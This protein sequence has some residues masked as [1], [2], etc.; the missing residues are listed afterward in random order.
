VRYFVLILAVLGFPAEAV[1]RLDTGKGEV[2]LY[3]KSYALVVG[4]SAYKHWPRLPGVKKDVALVK[5][6]L[7]K[8][9]FEVTTVMDPTRSGFDRA[10]RAF[11]AKQGQDATARL[12]F[13]YAG[14]GYT[15]KGA[16][17]QEMGYMVPVDTPLPSGGRG[18]IQSTAVSMLEIEIY[19]KQMD[20]KHALFLF[21]SCFSGSIFSLSRAVPAAIS[22]KTTKAVR[23][24]ITAG[25]ADQEVPDDSVF[26]RQF[27]AALDGDAD[28]NRDGYLTASELS[29]FLEESVIN[30]TRGAQT[31]QYGKIRDPYLDKGDFVFFLPR[32]VASPAV[33]RAAPRAPAKVDP[34][35]VE[36]SYWESIRASKDPALYQAYLDRYPKGQ[37]AELARIF[38]QSEKKAE[39]ARKAEK[40]RTEQARREGPKPGTV[41]DDCGDCPPMVVIPAG[42]FTMGSPA[43]ETGRWDNEGPQRKV[44]IARPFALGRNEVTFAE[45]ER[46]VEESGYKTEAE[47]NVGKKGCFGFNRV[48]P[49]ATKSEWQPGRTWRDPGIDQN[50]DRDPVV[51]VSWNDAK[52]YTSWLS[53]KTGKTYRL[54]TE[55]E[56]EYAARAGTKTSRYWGDNPSQACVYSNVGD[57]STYRTA[58]RR[59]FSRPAE[60]RHECNDGRYYTAPVG[61]YK[62][63]AFGLYDILGNVWEWTED[64]GSPSYKGAPTDGSALLTGDCSRRVIRG[65]GWGSEPRTVRSA[66]RARDPYDNRTTSIGFRLARTLE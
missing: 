1:L 41:F 18:A 57:Q 2:D 52:A 16:Q 20:A 38:A 10:M 59:T 66:S 19:A 7:E 29:Q 33:T 23:Q 3:G 12:L 26:R 37:F 48:A 47:R 62:A 34:L 32:A 5:A 15:L 14:H 60:R 21:D 39:E 58:F 4:A 54:P 36:L 61:S 63:N 46:F 17:G 30:Y 25:A 44:R 50:T 8:H 42:E 56:W 40:A 11:I 27:V 31:P 49:E 13:Y 22:D 45:F 51:C 65:G 43:P 53:K 28:L 35:A 9:G 64:C 24:F 6:A 55:A